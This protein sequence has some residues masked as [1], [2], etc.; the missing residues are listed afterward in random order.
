MVTSLGGGGPPHCFIIR[1]GGPGTPRLRP[2]RLS[3]RL[4]PGPVY[5]REGQRERPQPFLLVSCPSPIPAARPEGEGRAKRKRKSPLSDSG[6][7]PPLAPQ[8]R[9]LPGGA[10][11]AIPP[12]RGPGSGINRQLQETSSRGHVA[13]PP[14][15]PRPLV[16]FSGRT[17]SPPFQ[18]SG[19]RRRAGSERGGRLGRG[20]SFRGAGF[21]GRG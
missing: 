14:P 9:L 11:S 8:L 5:A 10:A 3:T 21:G 17:Q 12:G 18:A 6:L 20:A 2:G 7:L 16:G 19:P 15:P 4:R 1:R 13:R